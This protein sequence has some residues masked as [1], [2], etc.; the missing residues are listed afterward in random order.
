MGRS[1]R[2]HQLR[3]PPPFPVTVVMGALPGLGSIRECVGNEAYRGHRGPCTGTWMTGTDLDSRI[4]GKQLGN[5][6]S[7]PPGADGNETDLGAAVT[8]VTVPTAECT[9]N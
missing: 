9:S 3:L 7:R 4:P 6:G 8:Q 5:E 1:P 2:H